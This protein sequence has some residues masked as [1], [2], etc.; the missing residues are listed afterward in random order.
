M[1][2]FKTLLI[3]VLILST[4]GMYA[5]QIEMVKRPLDAPTFTYYGTKYKMKDMVT[6][7]KPNII[8][9]NHINQAR[10]NNTFAQI[11]NIPGGLLVGY[12]I[13]TA[14]AGGDANWTL[15]IVGGGLIALSVPFLT[16]TNRHSKKA[17]EHYNAGQPYPENAIKGH[18]FTFGMTGNGLSLALQF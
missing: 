9:S 8:A 2:N 1:T 6:I 3:A 18:T 14:I 4:S 12:P 11:L 17:V 15:A 13:G 5:Q 16:A 7:M 10:T